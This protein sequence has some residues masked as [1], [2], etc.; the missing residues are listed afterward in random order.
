LQ[1]AQTLSSIANVI[2][3][4]A[5]VAFGTVPSWTI[6]L[7]MMGVLARGLWRLRLG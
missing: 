6:I 7:V 4:A 1:N 3:T 5:I 2:V